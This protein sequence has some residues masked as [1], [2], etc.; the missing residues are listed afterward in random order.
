MDPAEIS[1]K[2][3][4]NLKHVA[5]HIQFTTKGN[6][7]PRSDKKNPW[8]VVDLESF[9]VAFT[10]KSIMSDEHFTVSFGKIKLF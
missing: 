10:E 4:F 6:V 5:P 3:N 1:K 9:I 7:F 2:H 8:H